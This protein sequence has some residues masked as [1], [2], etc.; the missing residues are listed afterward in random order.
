MGLVQETQRNK[1][2][3]GRDGEDGGRGEIQWVSSILAMHIF[4]GQRHAHAW[5]RR[6]ETRGIYKRNETEVDGW[7]REEE[8]M[9]G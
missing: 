7:K 3:G 6:P 4:Y 8:E 2:L 1:R 5:V 9:G